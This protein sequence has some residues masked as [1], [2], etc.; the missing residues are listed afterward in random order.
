MS[1]EASLAAGRRWWIYQKER[2]PVFAHGLLVLAFSSSAVCFSALL[3][4]G[5]A[6]E[7]PAVPGWRM[8]LAAFLTCFF[9]FLQL[10]IADEFKDFEEDSRWRPYRPVPRGLVTLRSLGFVFAGAAVFQG[11]LAWWHHPGLWKLLLATWAYLALMS[12]EFFVREWLTRRPIT[13]LWT[14]MLI[15]PLVDFYA[16]A[17]HWM[18]AL[19]APPSGL[20]W[21]LA[22][23]FCNGIV[24]ETG[25]KI[26]S[27]DLEEEGV[28][29]Y[30]RLWGTR[31]APWVWLGF[32]LIT[33]LCALMAARKIHALALVAPVLAALFGVAAFAAGR[34]VKKADAAGSRAF[35]RISGLWTLAMYLSLG[36]LPL[37]FFLGTRPR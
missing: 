32:V 34:F 35:E 20:G 17:C 29:T 13:Y 7:A 27:P 9:F 18:K 25:R 31:R 16:T 12:R 4:A 14:H 2:F 15:M 24:I 8:F 23:S 6:N 28:S 11:I 30:T 36:L 1:D 10:R 37:L 5:G 22:V 33:G 19:G 3:A 26:R 21:F